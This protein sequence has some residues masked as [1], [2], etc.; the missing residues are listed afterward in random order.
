MQILE[1]LP[2]APKLLDSLLVMK[3]EKVD[4]GVDQACQMLAV[5]ISIAS[6]LNRCYI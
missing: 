5:F 1:A 2:Q 3:L 4:W 6:S